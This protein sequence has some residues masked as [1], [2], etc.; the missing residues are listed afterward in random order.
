MVAGKFY[1][2]HVERNVYTDPC[3]TKQIDKIKQNEPFI[4]LEKGDADRKWVETCK[5]LTINGVVGWIQIGYPECVKP[6][7]ENYVEL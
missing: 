5:V 1:T 6:V 7:G 4:Y 2:Y 3:H